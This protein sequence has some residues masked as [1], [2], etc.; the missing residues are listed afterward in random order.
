M[1]LPILQAAR[2]ELE[3][4]ISK[5][6]ISYRPFLVKEEKVLLMALESQNRKQ[7]MNAMNDIVDACTFGEIKSKDLPVAELEYI[8]LKLRS[9]SVGENSHIGV[10]CQS[11]NESNELDI[12]LDDIKLDTTDIAS[13]KIMLTDTIGVIMKYPN[14]TDVTRSIDE[15]KSDVENTYA[16]IAACLDKIF[17][18]ENTYDVASQSKQEVQD[19]IESLNKQQ[20][21][22]IKQFFEK[23][24][25]LKHNV[26]FKCCKCGK[27]N[28]I[29]LEGTESFFA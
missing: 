25:K 29:I 26:V 21:D 18:T 3:L 28:D 19:F 10:K 8:F 2:F 15:K 16:V 4:P 7:I 9:K 11:C 20:F 12:N 6:T 14:T 22:K 23:L 27:D 5:K 13:T 17:D 24:P 1:A